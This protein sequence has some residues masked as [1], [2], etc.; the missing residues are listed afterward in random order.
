MGLKQWKGSAGS[1]H[2]AGAPA[3][4]QSPR[5]RYNILADAPVAQWIEHQTPDLVAEVRFLSGV[6]F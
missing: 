4:V 3:L 6:P 5:P 1:S 2:G